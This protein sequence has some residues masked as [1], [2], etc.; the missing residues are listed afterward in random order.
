[1]FRDK[2]HKF[3]VHVERVADKHYFQKMAVCSHKNDHFFIKEATD[4]SQCNILHTKLNELS[5]GRDVLIIEKDQI[6]LQKTFKTYQNSF[7]RVHLTGPNFKLRLPENDA[8]N[9]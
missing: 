9:F 2:T 8:S 7:F 6:S 4:E 5:D 1:M 3:V